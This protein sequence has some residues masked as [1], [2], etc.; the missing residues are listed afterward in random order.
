LERLNVDLRRLSSRLITMQDE[1]RR[2]VAREL[3]DGLGQDLVAAKML[4]D[5][6]NLTHPR[7]SAVQQVGEASVIINRSIQQIR[8]MSHLLHPPLLDEVG[9]V[10]ALT[11]YV[12]GFSKRS[13]IRTELDIE[14]T[15]FPRVA[16]ELETA[17]FRIVQEALT[18]VFRHAEARQAWIAL[19]HEGKRVFASVRDDGKGIGERAASLLPGSIGVGIGGMKQ[20]VK[21]FGGDLKFITSDT[22]T[23]VELVIPCLSPVQQSIPMAASVN[24][25]PA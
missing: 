23:T 11:W 22:G 2:R 8:S 12:E 4:L 21:E 1:E 13:G 18:N 24:S 25:N 14:P 17:V 20:R 15:E 9:L 7:S 3:H 6:F 19:H 10:S 16:P 5:S